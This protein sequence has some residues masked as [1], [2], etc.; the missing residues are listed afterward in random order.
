MIVVFVIIVAALGVGIYLTVVLRA[1]PG[2]V[3]ERL[4]RLEAL[5]PDLGQWVKDDASAEGQAASAE[6]LVR[7]T[8]TLLESRGG[9]F[10]GEQLVQ[11]VRYRE[12][13]GGKI[14]RV[15]PE[16]RTAR[17]RVRV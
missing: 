8:R 2:A 16:R 4:G 5:P 12:G 9:L 3:D 1:V 6:G 11:Q 14:V 15:E 10:G 17:R 7:E 13:E